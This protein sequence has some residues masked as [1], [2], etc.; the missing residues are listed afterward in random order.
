M[1]TNA[2]VPVN[3]LTHWMFEQLARGSDRIEKEADRIE[4]YTE[5]EPVRAM[6]LAFGAGVLLG[7]LVK[8]R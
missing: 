1:S 7:L 8:R 4:Q 5:N 3:G 6:L 2:A